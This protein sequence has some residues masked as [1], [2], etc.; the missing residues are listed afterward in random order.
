[1]H[2]GGEEIGVVGDLKRARSI[3]DQF[4]RYGMHR[5]EMV[6]AWEAGRDVDA[7]GRP[8]P[9]TL[10][11]QPRLWRALGERL[12]P[13]S[14]PAAMAEATNRLR[15]G[16]I[17]PELPP[18]IFMFGLASIPAPHLRV[19][20]ALSMLRSMWRSSFPLGLLR[21]GVASNNSPPPIV[22]CGQS[23]ARRTRRLSSVITR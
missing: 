10:R 9:E 7:L 1:L 8:L 22:W 2:S 20:L 12:G 21:C 3:A 19:L 13:L 14:G 6:R 18:R 5:S 23:N 15:L 17:T 4:D 11:W 16:R